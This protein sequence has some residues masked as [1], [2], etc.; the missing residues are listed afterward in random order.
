MNSALSLET[1]KHMYQKKEKRKRADADAES[2]HILYPHQFIWS[3]QEPHIAW[4]VD[5]LH[6]TVS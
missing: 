2:K 3:L 6:F 5:S 1:V 4:V